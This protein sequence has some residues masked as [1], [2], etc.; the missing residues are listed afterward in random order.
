MKGPPIVCSRV[1]IFPQ[2]S[3]GTP[4]MVREY[5]SVS[6]K[7]ITTLTRRGAVSIH[8][9][10]MLCPSPV[11]DP[12]FTRQPEDPLIAPMS[13]LDHMVLGMYIHVSQT[14]LERVFQQ[15]QPLVKLVVIFFCM[16]SM[17][18]A[19]LSRS[20]QYLSSSLSLLVLSLLILGR[21]FGL[22]LRS[23]EPFFREIRVLQCLQVG[24]SRLTRIGECR[25]SGRLCDCLCWSGV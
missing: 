19:P 1:R 18:N 25:R 6:M 8:C 7:G 22:T 17:D 23:F 2:H 16:G 3:P 11:V 21:S 20:N 15:Q 5:V 24:S 10:L 9:T 13:C 12:S 4:W 14:L